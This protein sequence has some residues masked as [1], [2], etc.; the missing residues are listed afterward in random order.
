MEHLKYPIGKFKSP[1]IIN[2]TLIKEWIKAIRDFPT[3]LKLEIKDLTPSDLKKT[4]R[5]N[6]WN[7]MQVVHHCA[8]SHMNSFIRCKL[9]L[10]ED[11]PTIKPYHENL[12]AALPDANNPSVE[13][14]LIILEGLHQRWTLL[15]DS[16]NAD[17]LNKSYF[18][19][20]SKSFVNLKTTIGIYAW[21][22]EHHLAHI[23]IAKTS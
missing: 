5:P 17:D 6:G 11:T 18:H 16:L 4:Y 15:L 23:K 13:S 3:Q 12:W 19:P 22:C 14:S 21:H 10:T 9:A 7:I 20:E 1:E 8:D 2:E